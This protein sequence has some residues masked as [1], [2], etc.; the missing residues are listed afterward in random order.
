MRDTRRDSLN[1]FVV[2][3]PTY[4]GRMFLFSLRNLVTWLI[5]VPFMKSFTAILTVLLFSAAFAAPQ[6]S[7][8][9]KFKNEEIFSRGGII[10]SFDFLP[11]E[12]IIYTVRNGGMHV[13][14]PKTKESKQLAGVP[15]VANVGQ[16][17]LLDVK[18]HPDFAKNNFVYFT[19][20]E[21]ISE[22]EMA[23]TFARAKL[24]GEKLT[25]L[26]KLL[27]AKN[28]GTD[29]I[30]FGSRI[31]FKGEHVFVT[32]GERNERKEVQ[33]L[34]HHNGKVVRLFHD[35]KVPKDNPFT[36][37]KDALPEIW[38]LGHRN[39]QGLA[40]HPTTGDLYEA[41]M[42]PRGGDEIN[43]IKPGANYGWPIVTHGREYYGLKIGDG[44]EKAGMEKPIVH[45]TPSI[46]P[47]NIAFY[48]GDKF[49]KW[50]DSLFVGCL[51]GQQ[52]RRVVL[53]GTKVAS[54]EVVLE[55]KRFRNVRSGPDGYLYY[56]TDD[57]KIG[58]LLPE[59]TAK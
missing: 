7:E 16:G 25:D 29:D 27:Q 15:A 8:S 44:A 58:R 18:L 42:G 9:E 26:Q 33:M 17:G 54:Q 53:D 4:A 6:Q 12:R 10:W 38:S 55:G 2:V 31:V 56:S 51:G 48:S 28:A 39:Q 46:S 47:S 35:G 45:W 34:S 43:L 50:K 22:K 37:Q 14:D 3:D 36:A 19:Y 59:T 57:G 32:I 11:D 49:P 20:S 21:N 30:H 13:F 23:T 1:A 24:S 40:L 52:I 5:E 41:E